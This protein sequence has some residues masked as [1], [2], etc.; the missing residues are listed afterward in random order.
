MESVTEC[1]IHI[2]I[3]VQR[4]NL[5]KCIGTSGTGTVPE[6]DK[7]M[8]KVKRKLLRDRREGKPTEKKNPQTLNKSL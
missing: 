2:Q 8:I 7:Q 3:R 4:N 6:E 5:Q 1:N